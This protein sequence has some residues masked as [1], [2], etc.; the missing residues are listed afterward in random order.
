TTKVDVNSFLFQFIQWEDE[1]PYEIAELIEEYEIETGMRYD[2]GKIKVVDIDTSKLATRNGYI[3]VKE[4][5]ETEEKKN[6]EW[7]KS[8]IQ[9]N[10]DFYND[11]DEEWQ[12]AKVRA[13][14]K[15]LDLINQL[16]EP[17][18]L[19]QEWLDENKSSWTKLK[20]DGYYIPV[21]KLQNLLVP[22]QIKPKELYKA[23]TGIS[24][25]IEEVYDSS[26]TETFLDKSVSVER[27]VEAVMEAV[28]PSEPEKPVIPKF[29]ADWIEEAKGRHHSL[30]EAMADYCSQE[31]NQW[32]QDFYHSD[33]FAKAWLNGYETEQEPR[34]YAKIKG[35]EN[36]GSNDKYW[37]YNTDMEE[38]S[39]GD[40]EVHPN[41][42]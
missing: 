37:N 6:I 22:K 24:P 39:V 18:V 40:S 30:Y 17:E 33:L 23:I 19:S 26:G 2:F 21:E 28:G 8:A 7:L 1:E 16:D 3:Y 35:H 10:L 11:K 4:S 20:V 9:Q 15:S 31:M 5:E 34:Y 29:V 27:I 42:I 41:V 13:Y 14:A 36:I 32:I 38:L 25:F 12:M